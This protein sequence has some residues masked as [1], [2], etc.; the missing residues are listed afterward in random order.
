[1]SFIKNFFPKKKWFS[2]FILHQNHLKGMISE[3]LEVTE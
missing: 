3:G 2:I 1:M